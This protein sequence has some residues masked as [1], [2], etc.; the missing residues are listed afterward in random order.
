MAAFHN[1]LEEKYYSYFLLLVCA[2][3]ILCN[4]IDCSKNKVCASQLLQEFVIQIEQ[5]YGKH[6]VSYNVHSL[7][8]LSEDVKRFGKLDNYSAFKFENFMQQMKKMV[9][10]GSHPLQQVRNRLKKRDFFIPTKPEYMYQQISNYSCTYPNN[11]FLANNKVYK[12]EVLDNGRFDGYEVQ[13]LGNMFDYPIPSSLISIFCSNGLE[14]NYNFN[15]KY[16]NICEISKI[17]KLVN[18][19]KIIYVPLQHT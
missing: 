15:I 13:N 5:L 11:Y 10:K 9:K 18:D 8:H 4:P 2:N 17:V 6:N 7:I 1:V 14:E 3:R 16:F 19:S 12:F